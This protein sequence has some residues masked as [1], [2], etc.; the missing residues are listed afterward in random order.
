MFRIIYAL[1]VVGSVF[2]T[3]YNPSL[4]GLL[5]L[6]VEAVF[7]L[8]SFVFYQI[9]KKNIRISFAEEY[10]GC[11]IKVENHSDIP[12]GRIFLIGSIKEN[13]TGKVSNVKLLLQADAQS[14]EIFD[15]TANRL[16]GKDDLYDGLAYPENAGTRQKL[17]VEVLPGSNDFTIEKIEFYD[18]LGL[19]KKTI[20]VQKTVTLYQFPEWV[21]IPFRGEWMVQAD[22]DDDI[23]SMYDIRVDISGRLSQKN[24]DDHEDCLLLKADLGNVAGERYSSKDIE[25]FLGTLLSVGLAATSRDRRVH[26]SI[27]GQAVIPVAD[28]EEMYS[29]LRLIMDSKP[30]KGVSGNGDYVLVVTATLKPSVVFKGKELAL[31]GKNW[32]KE[33]MELAD[34]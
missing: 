7:A 13:W 10:Q 17:N 8:I 15:V 20:T 21:N 9:L 3:L 14:E 11:T 19:F 30:G 29:A 1:I 26:V 31:S 4:P 32:K 25:V 33:I 16:S 18:P 2:F 6:M 34:L 28:E 12:L 24:L 5:L 27:P 22:R 23:S